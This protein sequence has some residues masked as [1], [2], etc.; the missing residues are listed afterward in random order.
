VGGGGGSTNDQAIKGDEK[1]R[2]PVSDSCM[3]NDEGKAKKAIEQV[4]RTGGK[5]VEERGVFWAEDNNRE[6]GLFFF[7]Y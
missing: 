5:G 3:R 6:K 2:K 1:Y 4:L 7:R